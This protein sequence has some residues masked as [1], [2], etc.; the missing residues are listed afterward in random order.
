MASRLKS[1][2]MAAAFATALGATAARAETLTFSNWKSTEMPAVQNE[3]FAEFRKENPKID[4]KIEEIGFIEYIQKME[5]SGRAG[6][7]PDAFELWV[8]TELA[9]FAEEGWIM[10]LDGFIAKEKAAGNDILAAYAPWAT[11]SYDGKVYVLPSMGLTN[12]LLWNKTAF[13]KAGLPPRAPRTM[14]E[15]V[16]F[17]KKLNNPPAMYGLG[18]DGNGPELWLALSW[19]YY[20][21]GVRIGCVDGEI[22]V[23]KP[24]AIE[25][26]KLIVDLVNKDKVVPSFTNT[27]FEKLRS[28]F[29]A[30]KVAMMPDWNG[31]PSVISELKPN[32]EWGIAP[33]PTWKTTGT[34]LTGGDSTYAIAA[35]AKNPEDAWKLIKFLTGFGA[36]K[37]I[38]DNWPFF[39]TRN[40][41]WMEIGKGTIKNSPDLKV[42][43]EQSKVANAYDPYMELPPQLF[44]AVDVYRTALHQ[45]I[46]GQ[47]Q[48]QAA[49][50]EVAKEWKEL[51]ADWHDQYGG[52]SA[53]TK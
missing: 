16:E 4:L 14:E 13:Q 42:A 20:T 45:V 44:Q 34:M 7:L 30:G 50:D 32:F 29:A 41:I 52:S 53:C 23:N 25:A 15:L 24:K 35:N 5:L 2:L 27:N 10:P 6:Q 3:L 8:P 46:A 40:D 18:L 43:L 19:F 48:P 22:Q 1:V 31:V 26:L 21:N 28:E 9:R 36:Q 11:T 38:A 51:F 39:I 17:A 33:L 49:M 47:K 12:V 37:K